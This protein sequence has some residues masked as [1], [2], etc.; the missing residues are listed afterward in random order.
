MQLA[1][2]AHMIPYEFPGDTRG[3]DPGDIDMKVGHII[4][5][6]E[7]QGICHMEPMNLELGWRA[8]L[9]AKQIWEARNWDVVIERDIELELTEMASRAGSLKECRMLWINARDMGRL[10]GPAKHMIKTRVKELKARG[11]TK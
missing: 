9:L 1:M 3:V 6:P 11:V 2:Y 4:Y 5:L 7:G 8:C 10:D